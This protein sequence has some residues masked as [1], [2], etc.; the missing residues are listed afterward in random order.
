MRYISPRRRS[1]RGSG[2][3]CFERFSLRSWRKLPCRDAVCG[4]EISFN[5][6]SLNLSGFLQSIEEMSLI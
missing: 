6:L 3:L 5:S 4:G 1:Y 2:F